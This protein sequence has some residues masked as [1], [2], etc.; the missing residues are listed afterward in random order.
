MVLSVAAQSPLRNPI[1]SADLTDHLKAALFRRAFGPPPACFWGT[2]PHRRAHRNRFPGFP[3]LPAAR[4][5][6]FHRGVCRSLSEAG[7]GTGVSNGVRRAINAAGLGLDR[8]TR[9]SAP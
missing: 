6:N 5:P 7:Q 3:N 2:D 8:E 1:R 4:S 9:E